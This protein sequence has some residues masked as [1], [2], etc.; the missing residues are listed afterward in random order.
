MLP[1]WRT[2]SVFLSFSHCLLISVFLKKTIIKF[3]IHI[4]NI[5]TS[6]QLSTYLQKA[7][8]KLF[9]VFGG[10]DWIPSRNVS[11]DQVPWRAP[12]PEDVH[13]P[14]AVEETEQV[15]VNVEGAAA[16]G[17]GRST[18]KESM[19]LNHSPLNAKQVHFSPC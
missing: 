10:W 9:W 18:H 7:V 11:A 3:P 4:R 8:S 17:W 5:E 2:A 15:A 16:G 6:F 12:L 13:S 1:K 19:K 14:A